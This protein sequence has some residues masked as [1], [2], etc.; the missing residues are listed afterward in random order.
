MFD[1]LWTPWTVA[2]QVLCPQDS[3]GKNT[4]VGCHALL[5]ETFPTQGSNQCS[6]CLLHWRAGSLPLAPPRKLTLSNDSLN[7]TL[8]PGQAEAWRRCRCHAQG[9]TTGICLTPLPFSKL[10][11][12]LWGPNET[13]GCLLQ[14]VHSFPASPAGEGEEFNTGL[15]AS[16][17]ISLM[18]LTSTTL[19]TDYS[20]S[21]SHSVMSD[22]LRPHGLYSSWNSPGQN[23]GVGSLSLLQGIFPTQGSNPGLLHCRQ[24][25]YQLRHKGNPTI[26]PADLLD[27]G[28]ELGSPA[29]QTDSLPTELSGKP[30]TD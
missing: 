26:S 14:W 18:L 1:S 23:T 16:R 8:R 3:P 5:W 28:V 10:H 7:A 12:L 21:E 20:E 6:L 11:V 15:S 13:H 22:S 17:I 25:L 4:G 2:L 30:I 19:I 29:L 27:L 9:H 24:I